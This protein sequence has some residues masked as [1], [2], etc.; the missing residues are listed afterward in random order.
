MGE[1]SAANEAS[2]DIVREKSEDEVNEVRRMTKAEKKSA[3]KKKNKQQANDT[4]KKKT[5]TVDEGA[6]VEDCDSIS[7][8]EENDDNDSGCGL[9]VAIDNNKEEISLDFEDMDGHWEEA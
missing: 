1:S 9:D 6:T 3:K 4:D 7:E 5:E 8:K 2:L